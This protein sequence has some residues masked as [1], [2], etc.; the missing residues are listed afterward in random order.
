[1]SRS[2][3]NS[4]RLA[5]TLIELL[6]VIAII[7]IL[8]ALLVPAV[9]KVREAAARTQCVNNLKQLGLAIQSYHDV[10]K[11]FPP[12][13]IDDG[14]TWAVHILPYIEQDNVHKAFDYLKPWPDQPNQAALTVPLP[15]FVCPFRRGPMLSKP[16]SDNGN[17]ISGWE[18]Y[19]QT[20]KSDFKRGA[21]LAGPCSDY[22]AVYA[23]NDRMSDKTEYRGCL[24]DQTGMLLT[25]CNP[26]G[27]PPDRSR[28]RIAMVTDGL[29]NTLLLGERH[30]RPDKLG[31]GP[32]TTQPG[33][34][35][36]DNCIFN[37]DQAQTSGRIAGPRFLLARSPDEGTGSPQL[38]FG[39]YHSGIVNFVFG[40]G[41]VRAIATSIDGTNLGRLANRKDGQVYTGPPY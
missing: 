5:F 9:Q 3:A 25:V 2:P 22:A 38:R 15:I 8:I 27:Y 33:G 31:H 21:H 36:G 12:N 1:M 24:G 11:L 4:R 40:D 14:A 16:N 39:S 10:R 41:A 20:K 18:P 35:D 34:N 13:R 37:G 28:T 30:V 32:G 7:A 17:G 29:S 19:L 6:V 23:D 26:V